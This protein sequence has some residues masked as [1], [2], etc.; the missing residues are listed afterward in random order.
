MV[1]CSDIP[2]CPTGKVISR[3][4][5]VSVDK[6]GTPLLWVSTVSVVHGV[7]VFNMVT[8]V[9]ST[10]KQFPEKSTA[11]QIPPTTAKKLLEPSQTTSQITAPRDSL[12]SHLSSHEQP[13][14]ALGPPGAQP[15]TL[16]V[17]LSFQS[18]KK[19]VMVLGDMTLREL[20]TK[21]APRGAEPKDFMLKNTD[22]VELDLDLKVERVVTGPNVCLFI[23][24]ASSW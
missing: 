15:N 11:K 18:K 10:A 23:E 17:V 13:T 9:K 3:A 21:Y 6:S 19:Q 20:L 1:F 2:G 12:S 22:D 8:D 14:Q 24:K 5:C 7:F 16:T 4:V